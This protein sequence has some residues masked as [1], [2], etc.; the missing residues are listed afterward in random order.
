MIILILLVCKLFY[1]L[2]SSNI[3]RIFKSFYAKLPDYLLPVLFDLY[4][5]SLYLYTQGHIKISW[6]KWS[7]EWKK[8]KKLW[9]IK[10]Y[11]WKWKK[12]N[13]MSEVSGNQE[14]P[15]IESFRLKITEFEILISFSNLYYVSKK[16]MNT[17]WY[18]SEKGY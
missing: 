1:S 9:S 13:S 7:C 4:F 6:V 5:C 2:I 17:S 12:N 3:A 14:Y 15:L 10:I 11:R 18:G 8:I 16:E